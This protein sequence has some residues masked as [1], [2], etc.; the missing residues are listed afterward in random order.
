MSWLENISFRGAT[1]RVEALLRRFP[2]TVL[3]T[4]A[5]T[6]IILLL[7]WDNDF[8]PNSDAVLFMICF[9]PPTAALLGLSLHLWSEEQTNRHKSKQI[10]GVA[11]GLWF[12]FCLTISLSLFSE[13]M[14][15]GIG[16]MAIL[17]LIITSVLFLS[18]LKKK[19]D[20]EAWNFAVN[21]LIGGVISTL[22]SGIL[23]GGIAL[24]LWGIEMLFDLD[25]PNDLYLSVV[26]LCMMTLNILLF[27][28]QIPEGEAKHCQNTHRM[29][30]FGKV[31]VHA[32]FVPLQA[33]YLITLYI[34]ALTILI[35]WELPEGG[36]VWLVT[37]M[38]MGM[39]FIITLI[40]P[41]LFHDDKPFDKKLV[42]WLA[43]LAL[44]L[45]V[46]MTV[47]IWRRIVDYGFTV[48]RIYV[49]LFNIWCY[50]VCIYL[51]LH[52][53]K[54]IL[55][56]L[57][58]FV[59]VFFIASV[60]PWNVTATTKRIL[61]NQVDDILAQTGV[62]LP[63]DY[64][65]FDS[66]TKTM[67]KH[68]ADILKG[69]LSYLKFDLDGD[70]LVTRWLDG[71]VDLHTNPWWEGPNTNDS[72]EIKP[73]K[74]KPS[75]IEFPSVNM[76][77]EITDMPKGNFQKVMKVDEWFYKQNIQEQDSLLFLDFIYSQ[78][79]LLYSTHFELPFSRL[80]EEATVE[81]GNHVPFFIDNQEASLLIWFFSV[82]QNEDTERGYNS[83]DDVPNFRA[84]I[85][86]LHLEGMLFLREAAF[87]KAPLEQKEE[88]IEEDTIEKYPER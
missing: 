9:Y 23:L 68:D 16:M 6:I 47:G 64:T 7:I 45:L 61:T 15:F 62:R 3:F 72:T 87:K 39:L 26:I 48:P 21:L 50:V 38:M 75:D 44:P 67:S 74:I 12:L 59:L 4:V 42:R 17:T 25:F 71:L 65:R 49:I 27:L 58:S 82:T 20:I 88:I 57:I 78:D 30:D 24:L 29:N 83:N 13:T 33:A 2:I 18:F 69:K 37:T 70:S 35:A 51:F 10:H 32:L 36:V 66:L 46:L 60:G 56:I 76:E 63:L 53:A 1:R 54:R 31:V 73:V 8:F 84:G 41:L 85:K 5:F 14:E 11:Q 55:W 22:V 80:Q 77:Y 86:D 43:A 81:E 19:D 40:Y 28:M 79:T 52:R 34:Y